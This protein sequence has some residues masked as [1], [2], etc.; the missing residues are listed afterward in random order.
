MDQRVSRLN[1]AEEERMVVELVKN[2]QREHKNTKNRNN[3]SSI[4][5]MN[6]ISN[7]RNNNNF[8]STDTDTDTEHKN[9]LRDVDLDSLE[10]FVT[11][12]PESGT[13]TPTEE[14][15]MKDMKDKFSGLLQVLVFLLLQLQGDPKFASPY[16][17]ENRQASAK[18][19]VSP[20]KYI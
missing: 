19:N 12:T 3:I 13:S 20:S 16:R 7:N 9:P 11:T 1:T 15:L 18:L 10:E 8:T 14:R 6:N 4:S 5:N 17:A 2:N